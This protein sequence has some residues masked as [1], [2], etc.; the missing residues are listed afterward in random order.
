M[1]NKNSHKGTKT[2]RNPITLYKAKDVVV[3]FEEI[4]TDGRIIKNYKE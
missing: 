2:Q 3:G 4:L 1:K